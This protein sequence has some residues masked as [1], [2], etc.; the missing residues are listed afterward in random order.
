MEDFKRHLYSNYTKTH[1]NV[2]HGTIDLAKVKN[3]FPIKHFYYY[4]YLPSNKEASILEIGC[5]N[6][7]F[8]H[9]LHTLGY[10][11]AR[12]I[13]LSKEQIESGKNIGIKN[14]EVAEL[15]SYVSDQNEKWDY[16]FALDVIEHLTRQEAF[17]A[18][19]SCNKALKRGGQFIMQVPNGEGLFY[20]SIYYGDYTHEMPYT[21]KSA[22]Q[23]LLNAG[24]SK[25]E[26]YPVNPYPGSWK[27]KIRSWLWRLKVG[28]TRFWKMVETGSPSGIFTSNLIAKGI[29]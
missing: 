25:I 1:S 5:G 9:Y 4:P 28:Q 20:T 15:G 19:C 26:C 24:F 10:R 14:I 17:D 8:I 11:N 23:V 16:I 2:L 29:K 18:F 7:N 6:G 13:D 12:G 21:L 3:S 22:R 27:G